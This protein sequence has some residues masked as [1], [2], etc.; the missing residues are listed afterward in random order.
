MS[1]VTDFFINEGTDHK[2]RTH[3]DL[4]NFTDAE[5]EACHDHIQWMFPLHERSYH[6]KS[7]EI[8]ILT[9]EDIDILLLS[10]KASEAMR[11]GFKRFI[12]FLLSSDT[13]CQNGNHNLLRITRVI[14]SLRLFGKDDIA[15][16]MHEQVTLAG[17]AYDLDPVTFKY[18]DDALKQPLMHS[19]T[20]RFLD[21]KRID[22]T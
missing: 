5:F 22:I 1:K 4:V 10:H 17:K 9:E 11:K 21:E 14:R 13:W 16:R 19:M 18:W 20:K 6:A 15:K 3:A 8:P 7:D 2:G 12:K